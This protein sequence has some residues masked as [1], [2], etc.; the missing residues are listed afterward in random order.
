MRY[1]STRI[2]TTYGCPGFGDIVSQ[3]CLHTIME[4]TFE[5]VTLHIASHCLIKINPETW[6]QSPG[7]VS[8]WKCE[9]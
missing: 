3:F 8:Q 5:T 1:M 7:F 9:D 4:V 6:K 2:K